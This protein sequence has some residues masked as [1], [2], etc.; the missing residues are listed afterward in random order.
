MPLNSCGIRIL[1]LWG[2]ATATGLELVNAFSAYVP[3]TSHQNGIS[4]STRYITSTIHEE[5]STLEEADS[6]FGEDMAHHLLIHWRGEGV[7]GYSR[8]FRQIEFQ[9]A[10]A[11][12]LEVENGDV[13][14]DFVNALQYNGTELTNP[15]KVQGYN[16]AMQ[17]LRLRSLNVSISA[18]IQAAQ[19]CALIHAVY[20]MIATTT[21]RGDSSSEN[22]DR[23]CK[24]AE[25]V[26]AFSDMRPGGKHGNY[27]WCVRVRH[28]GSKRANEADEKALSAIKERRYGA[29]ARS[30]TL[31]RRALVALTPVL[32]MLGGP[33]DLHHPDYKIYVFDGLE[34]LSKEK[35][36]EEATNLVLARR[37]ATGARRQ[38]TS[39][40]PTSRICVTNTP[41]CPIAAFIMANVARVRINPARGGCAIL[42]PFCGSGG[43]LL[44]AALVVEQRSP[45]NN[46]ARVQLVGIEISHDGLVNRDNLRRDFQTRHLTEPVALLHGDSTRAEVRELA[47]AAIGHRPFDAILTDPPYGIRESNKGGGGGEITAATSRPIDDLLQM[48]IDDRAAGTPLLR[49]GGRMVAFI[50]HRVEEETLREIFPTSDQL[51]AAG[52]MCEYSQEQPLNDALSRWLVSYICVR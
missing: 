21:S 14:V 12:V 8:Q 28:Y 18:C 49:F 15:L 29:R 17:Y 43:T 9:S 36:V 1:V 26:D 23:L 10:L 41:L 7:E 22:Y 13:A 5:L 35:F 27:S 34:S 6:S 47:R 37:I 38:L 30:L 39:I 32:G 20:E 2:I 51:D 24:A 33:V 50:P 31:E 52:L 40:H 46:D 48:I 25:G 16:E 11:G 44:A 42:D 45:S 19:R 3:L 4:C